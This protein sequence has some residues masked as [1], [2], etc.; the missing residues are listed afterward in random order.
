MPRRPRGVGVR[1]RPVEAHIP[2]T[3]LAPLPVLVRSRHRLSPTIHHQVLV[4]GEPLIRPQKVNERP[5]RGARSS[6]L[7]SDRRERVNATR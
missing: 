2:T 4:N 3:W 6:A 7:R 5:A 1:P